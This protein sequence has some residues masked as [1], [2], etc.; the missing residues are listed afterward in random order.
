VWAERLA[1]GQVLLMAN[2][3]EA[4]RIAALLAACLGVQKVLNRVSWGEGA[5]HSAVLIRMRCRPVSN[6]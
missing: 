6:G 3:V 5:W 1:L 2:K 4:H